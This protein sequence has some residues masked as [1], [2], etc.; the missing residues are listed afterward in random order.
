MKANMAS[1]DLLLAVALAAFWGSTYPIIRIAGNPSSILL[2]RYVMASLVSLIGVI[3]IWRHMIRASRSNIFL[4]ILSG[5]FNACFVVAMY[6]ALEYIPSGP[7]SAII[8]T[9]PL[10][11]LLISSLMGFQRV[12]GGVVIGSLVAFSGV[13]LIYA[14]S[15]LN[16][17]GV[18]LSLIAS[19]LFAIASVISSRVF[20]DIVALT[21]IQNLSGLPIAV[22]VYAVAGHGVKIDLLTSIAILHQGVGAGYMAYLA[23]YALIKRSIGIASSIVY[24]VPAASYL[25]A[26]PVAGEIPEPHQVLGLLLI[27]AG[28]YIARRA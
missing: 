9:Y 11:M 4:S 20:L 15:S 27:L 6:Y 12:R 3:R 16:T 7:V 17:L 8:Y 2:G 21:S 19:I 22:M 26:I 25:I 28:I 10:L 14:P 5:F 24:M 13:L 18:I 1:S 23:W